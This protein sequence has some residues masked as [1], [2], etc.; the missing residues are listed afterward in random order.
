MIAEGR[1]GEAANGAAGPVFISVRPRLLTVAYGPPSA[2]RLIASEACCGPEFCRENT[3]NL[4]GGCKSHKTDRL[5]RSAR[6]VRHCAKSGSSSKGC[7][8]VLYSLGGGR[9][10]VRRPNSCPFLNSRAPISAPP[11]AQQKVQKSPVGPWSVRSTESCF[12]TSRRP[13]FDG[14]VTDW[15]APRAGGSGACDSVVA[16]GGSR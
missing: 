12:F 7:R 6:G 14:V 15:R 11:N 3:G 1:G 9:R 4:R 13:V 8:R 16:R 5:R 10:A 2:Q